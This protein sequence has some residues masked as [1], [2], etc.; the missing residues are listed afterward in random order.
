MKNFIIY[1]EHKEVVFAGKI[2]C[3]KRAR[4]APAF[5]AHPSLGHVKGRRLSCS[6]GKIAAP[7]PA[8]REAFTARYADDPL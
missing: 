6:T 1:F 2:S 8:I 7:I 3:T 4:Y 5:A